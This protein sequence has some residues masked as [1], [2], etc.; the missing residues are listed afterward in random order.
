MVVSDGWYV[1]DKGV[2]DPGL[3]MAP[4]LLY[5]NSLLGGILRE[6]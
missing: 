1:T 3:T 6:K 4:L 2:V 5:K